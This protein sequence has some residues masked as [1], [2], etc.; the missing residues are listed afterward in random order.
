MSGQVFDFR[1]FQTVR[2]SVRAAGLDPKPLFSQLRAAQARG[3]Q[4]LP[5]VG[6]AQ[7]LERQFRDDHDNGPEAA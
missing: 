7:Q 3:E 4:G 2:N 5:I 6:K 1:Q